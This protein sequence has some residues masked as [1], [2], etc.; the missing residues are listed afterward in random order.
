MHSVHIDL[1][2]NQIGKQISFGIENRRI[3]YIFT[4]THFSQHL[5]HRHGCYC[6]AL[7]IN[8]NVTGTTS[9]HR[10]VGEKCSETVAS[11]KLISKTRRFA[12]TMFRSKLFV[13]KI[14][15]TKRFLPVRRL[16]RIQIMQRVVISTKNSC[17]RE[18]IACQG[19]CTPRH[20]VRR[21]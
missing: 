14:I 12:N 4:C 10:N 17:A 15:I 1:H 9:F 21:I 19:I 16:L 11:G 6:C 5:M 2:S 3:G 7:H 8:A 20:V 18:S 13:E